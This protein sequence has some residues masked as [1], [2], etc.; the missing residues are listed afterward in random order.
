MSVFIDPVIDGDFSQPVEI[1]GSG[2]TST[3]EVTNAL[4]IT[5]KYAVLRDNY[6]PLPQSTPDIIYTNAVLVNETTSS[7][8]G[9]MQ[10]FERHYSTIPIP[11]VEY[12]EIP[13]TRPGQSKV[14]ISTISGQAIGWNQYGA[15]APYTRLV[16][17]EVDFTYQIGPFFAVPDI[18]E[19]SVTLPG[20]FLS[21]VDY[22]GNVYIPGGFVVVPY[23]GNLIT[24]QRWKF[25]GTTTPDTLPSTWIQN[26]NV[27]RWKGP[28]WQM[29]VIRI[30]G[31]V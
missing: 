10:F 16:N 22:I 31:L 15:A 8:Q 4:I 24:E 5:R 7:I 12:R 17:A 19:I 11:R 21:V 27:T 13:F 23:L 2:V 1:E 28:I 26:V 18:T 25:V 6:T 30:T 14:V 20:S 3:D 9:P 29:E